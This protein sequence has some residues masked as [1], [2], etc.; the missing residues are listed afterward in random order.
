MK[1]QTGIPKTDG[2]YWLEKWGSPAYFVGDTIY[3]EWH[4]SLTQNYRYDKSFR[5]DRWVGPLKNPFK[6]VVGK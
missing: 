6:K 2:W 4:E 3:P 5:T 1:I